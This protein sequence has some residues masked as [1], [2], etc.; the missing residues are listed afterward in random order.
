MKKL[1]F[2]F[3]PL[4]LQA[5][6]GPGG[7]HNYRNQYFVETGTN[8][9]GGVLSAIQAGF[10]NLQSIDNDLAH[11][12]FSRKLLMRYRNVKIWHGDSAVLL[13]EMIKDIPGQITFFLDAH[14]FPAEDDGMKNCPLMEELEQIRLH[15]IKTHTILIDDMNC[16]SQ[17][18][19]DYITKED[20]I[21]KL[22]E[23]NPQYRISFI[24][25]GSEGE[26]PENIMLAVPPPKNPG[27]G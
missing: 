19:F 11:V 9:G 1:L 2:L 3:F 12:K 27:R 13:W 5:V 21:R 14:R 25:G 8:G 15:P 20:L 23:I 16:C 4:F 7:F 18:A 26:A 24:T 22:Y 17:L 6:I 10:R